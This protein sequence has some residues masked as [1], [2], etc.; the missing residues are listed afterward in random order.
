[1]YAVAPTAADKTQPLIDEKTGASITPTVATPDQLKQAAAGTLQSFRASTGATYLDGPTFQS[2]KGTLTEADIVREGDR[3]SLKPGLT[4]EAIKA[5]GTTPTSSGAISPVAPSPE[6][7]VAP[8]T[9]TTFDQAMRDAVSGGAKKGYETAL[10]APDS[11]DNQILR[12]KAAMMAS[13]LG[14]NVTPEDLRWLSPSQQ[15]AVRSGKK[16]AIEAEL[17]GLNAIV[18]G[19]RDMRKEEAD[20]QKQEER[21]ALTRISTLSDL[22]LL[23]SLNDDALGKLS[24]QT[25]LDAEQLKKMRDDAKEAGGIEW[26]IDTDIEGNLIKYR[27]DPVSGTYESEVIKKKIV[28]GTGSAAEKDPTAKMVADFGIRSGDYI[29]QLDANK[30][31]SSLD[32]GSA[33]DSLHAEFP[34]IPPDVIDTTLGGRF[35]P[36]TGKYEGRATISK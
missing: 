18:T 21:D 27:F 8:Q 22:G 31:E 1:M 20:R 28:K 25:G 10:G 9:P 33:W 35:N 29:K 2:L 15:A 11:Y 14:D 32:W 23:G 7:P 6:A 34:D 5:R 30:L 3:I 4:V 17:V 24:S 19:R 26:K 13:M 36:D 12:Q 16:S